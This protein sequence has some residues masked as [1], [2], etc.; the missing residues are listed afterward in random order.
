MCGGV[1]MGVSVGRGGGI[2]IGVRLETADGRFPGRKKGRHT[3][4]PCAVLA[5]KPVGRWSW[6]SYPRPEAMD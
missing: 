6:A 1:A 4:R 3:S 2:G 5:C